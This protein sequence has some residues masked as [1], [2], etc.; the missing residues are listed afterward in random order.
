MAANAVSA[1]IFEKCLP[2]F[3]TDIKQCGTVTVCDVQTVNEEQLAEVFM[4]SGN[5]RVMDSL[6][7]HDFEIKTC[8][9]VQNGLYDF[10]MANKVDMSHKLAKIN[11]ANGR[12]MIMPFVLALQKSRINNEYWRVTGGDTTGVT[13]DEGWHVTVIS[14]TAM[15][16]DVRWFLSRT[17]VYIDGV[18]AGG[19]AT[20]TA[21][22]VSRA[23]IT[24]GTVLN[25]YLISENAGS[26]LGTTKA[27]TSNGSWPTSGLLIRGTPNVN[28][29]EEW[30]EE[31]PGLNVNKEV[32]F[33]IETVRNSLCSSSLYE[34][35]REMIIDANPYYKKFADVPEVEKNAQLG[36]DW[37]RQVVNTFWNNKRISTNQDLT[38]WRSLETIETHS[39]DNLDLP[40]EGVCI[41]YRAN[42]VGVYEQL[43]ECGQVK[44]LLGLVLNLQELFKALYEISRIRESNGQV[45]DTIDAFT[46]SEYAAKIQLA[47]VRYFKMK[48]EDTLHMTVDIT[49]APTNS[50][51]GFR[52]NSYVLD[53]PPITLNIVSHKYFDD[54]IAA[55]RLISST[56]EKASRFLWI[57]DWS[58]IYPGIIASNRVVNK[59]GDLASRA[60]V[61]SS[62]MCVMK[63][64]TQTQTLTSMTWTIVV[65][66]PA[67]SLIL[68][69][70]SDDVPEHSGVS[71]D[72]AI[73]YYGADS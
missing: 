7:I 66:C 42:A 50:K 57:I 17:R 25:L 1:N 53:W 15:P 23:V 52:Y 45:S 37:Q 39:Q 32:P 8:Q 72:G 46:D 41:G 22:R 6:L 13:G 65:E 54:R 2:A 43:A 19:A 33:W 31:G 55:A 29:Y 47:M 40:G 34:Q 38:N 12:Y 11:V 56:H 3:G 10:I 4:A 30:C 71:D 48:S 68:E 62:Y 21:W 5:Y 58:G 36:A 18:S 28:D 24:G 16:V 69:N 49:K 51:F 60:A 9:K 44:D 59:T 63:V 67:S 73:D 26:Y 61:D 27:P 35:Y 70:I 20:R 64:P 14:D